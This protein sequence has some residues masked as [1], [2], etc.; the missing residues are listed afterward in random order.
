MDKIFVI[1]FND[2]RI[3]LSQRGNLISLT[4]IPIVLA[5]VFGLSSAPR[6]GS[7]AVDFIDQDNTPASQAL[8]DA[9]LATND[10]FVR[11]SEVENI[12]SA[13][14]RVGEGTASAA[15]VIPQGFAQA[16][17]TFE[18]LP[19]LYFSREDSFGDPIQH[20]VNTVISQLNSS[21]IAA[22]AG[23]LVL[24]ALD[25]EAESG[26]LYARAQ[27]LLAQELVVYDLRLSN[28]EGDLQPGE[29]FGQSVPGLGAMFVMFT[30]L[31][32]MATLL[33]DRQNWTLQRVI[34][35]PVSRAQV[36]GGKILSLFILGMIQ[37]L[38][39]F[40]FGGLMGLEIGSRIVLLV[41]VMAAFA[42]CITALTF[43]IASSIGS[44]GQAIYL[45]NLLSV[46]LA[47]L[48]GGWWPLE[49]VPPFMQTLGHISP[50]AWVMDGFNT[51]IYFDGGLMDILPYVSVLFGSSIVL[52]AIGIR[53]FRI[54]N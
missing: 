17:Q 29:G 4:A 47:A 45:A 25:I 3:Y 14:T 5:A 7:I 35:M 46:T 12:E 18:A 54:V 53:R 44:E 48:G 38:I 41:F 10:A 19:I 24:N 43:A 33:R 21:I 32:G 39:L 6:G 42:L 30:V 37:Y 2:L 52:F 23:E 11:G 26:A 28:S 8:V 20:S 49:V 36:L 9:L 15:I 50:V 22:R 16:L 27:D 40:G 1:A 51:L 34:V 13:R 31:G